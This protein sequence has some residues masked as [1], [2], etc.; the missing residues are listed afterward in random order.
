MKFYYRYVNGL[1]EPDAVTKDIDP[2]MLGAILH[3]VMKKLYYAYTGRVLTVDVI[4][5]IIRDK[6]LIEKIIKSSISEKFSEEESRAVEGNEFIIRDVLLTYV[7]KILRTDKTLAPFKILHLETSFSFPVSVSS[8]GSQVDVLTGGIVDRIDLTGG[9]SRIVD[10]KT[11]SV[12]D[13]ITSIEDLFTDDRKRD[14]D[15][16]LQTLLYCEAY[17]M[18]NQ[19]MSLRPSVYSIRKMTAS[20]DN[21]KLKIKIDGKNEIIVED[22]NQVRDEYIKNLKG[23]ISDIFSRDEPFVMT[24]DIRGKCSYCPYRRLCLR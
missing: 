2:A 3:D 18:N 23:V 10:Y 22:Y 19:G 14:Y 4:D 15:A 24:N 8:G 11:G 21:D 1:K 9:V 20:S 6:P 13:K 12:A 17:L 5:L 16:W 7:L